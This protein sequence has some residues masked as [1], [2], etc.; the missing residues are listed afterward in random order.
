MEKKKH[1]NFSPFKKNASVRIEGGG[2]GEENRKKVF[3]ALHFVLNPER[4]N[5]TVQFFVLM[6]HS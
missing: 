2:V 6:L 4:K 3:L 1:M 5:Y